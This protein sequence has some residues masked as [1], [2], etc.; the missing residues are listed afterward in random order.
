M[1]IKSLQTLMVLIGSIALISV[2]QAHEY[3]L[4]DI[5]ITH[6]AARATVPQQSSGAA[7]LGL[8]NHGK[9]GDR[10]VKVESG[11]ADSV[12]IHSMEMNGDVMKMRTVDS[13][14]LAAGSK[15]SMKPGGAYHIMLIGL[16]HPLKT[17]DAFPL[18][19]Y[20]AKAGKIDVMVHVEAAIN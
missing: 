1:K 8:E 20:F 16:K 15:V 13:V 9:S 10:L 12:E 2:S 6:P 19:L 4:A 7:Y 17:G 14:E 18:T 11:V 5:Q 3:Q